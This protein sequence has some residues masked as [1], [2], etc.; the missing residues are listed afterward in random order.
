MT[1]PAA[2]E[3]MLKL[4]KVVKTP[5]AKPSPGPKP[6]V[7]PRPSF[8]STPKRPPLSLT[9]E[10]ILLGSSEYEQARSTASKPVTGLTLPKSPSLEQVK[11][12]LASLPSGVTTRRQKNDK[13]EGPDLRL[14]VGISRV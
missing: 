6:K 8:P 1:T 10:D 5:K 3:I 2:E 14:P 12:Y 13:K 4:V 9:P 7:P 11:D